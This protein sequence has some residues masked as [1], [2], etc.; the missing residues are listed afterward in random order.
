MGTVAGLLVAV[1]HVQWRRC[2]AGP[3]GRWGNW[4][5]R[6]GEGDRGV[7]I[8][9]GGSWS[10]SMA[11]EVATKAAGTSWASRCRPRALWLATEVLGCA[12]GGR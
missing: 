10:F 4:R 7:E 6:E 9:M 11:R 2:S 3:N 5:D 1:G 12:G 8:T